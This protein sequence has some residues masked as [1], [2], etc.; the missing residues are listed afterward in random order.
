[1]I[2]KQKKQVKRSITI[3][4]GGNEFSVDL[5]EQRKREKKEL[6]YNNINRNN[7]Q[8]STFQ[9]I[10]TQNVPLNQIYGN[11]AVGDKPLSVKKVRQVLDEI[12]FIVDW[13]P[14]KNG[15]KPCDTVVTNKELKQYDIH[16]LL[17][18]YEDNI[19][20]PKEFE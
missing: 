2:K 7:I 19:A 10:N 4:H 8:I 11:L 12:Q 20:Y 13:K 17:D 15:Y 6:S 3:L 18:Y 1:M 5:T 16:F 9:P 14:R